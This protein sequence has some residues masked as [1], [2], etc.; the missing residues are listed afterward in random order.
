[1]QEAMGIVNGIT[2]FANFQ[3]YKEFW[4]FGDDQATR[5][6]NYVSQVNIFKDGLIDTFKSNQINSDEEYGKYFWIS[7]D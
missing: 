1:M 4:V 2:R 6:G 7:S 3:R 5:D